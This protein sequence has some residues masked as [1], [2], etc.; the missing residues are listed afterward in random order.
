MSE[1]KYKYCPKCGNIMTANTG[2][3]WCKSCGSFETADGKVYPAVDEIKVIN[4]LA[5][6]PTEATFWCKFRAEA[7]KAAMAACLKEEADGAYPDPEEICGM[8]V[9]YADELIR[10]LKDGKE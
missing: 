1:V 8:A 5:T 4:D 6:H 2:G 7:A 3:W 10:L 9:L